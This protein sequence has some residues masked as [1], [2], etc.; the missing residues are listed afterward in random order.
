M[1]RRTTPSGQIDLNLLMSLH[2]LLEERNVSRAAKK[3]NV[4]QPTMSKTLRRLRYLFAD[5]LLV[6]TGRQYTLTPFAEDLSASVAESLFSIDRMFGRRALF[7]PFT[8]TREFRIACSDAIEFLVVR[9]LVQRL[10]ETYPHLSINVE[11]FNGAS[12]WRMIES[13][14]LDVCVGSYDRYDGWLTREVLFTDRRVCA[15]WSGNRIVGATLTWEELR[16]LPH[17]SH[18]WPGYDAR[19]GGYPEW[20]ILDEVPLRFSSS[21]HLARLMQLRDTQLVTFTFERLAQQLIHQA[22]IRVVMPPF[23]PPIVRHGLYWHPKQTNEPEH[24]WLRSQ[25]REIARSI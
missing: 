21:H 22:D 18:N 25:L 20:E 12:T 8:S 5:E 11:S 19:S 24:M 13:G 17:A 9:P 3:V 6:R 10:A 4:S 23:A 14:T 16:Q 1:N 2:A 7:D 15:V